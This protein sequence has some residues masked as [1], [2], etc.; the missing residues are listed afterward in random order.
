VARL[1]QQPQQLQQ[2]ER[3]WVAT[4]LPVAGALIVEVDETRNATFKGA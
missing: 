4:K 2:R 1:A 3:T